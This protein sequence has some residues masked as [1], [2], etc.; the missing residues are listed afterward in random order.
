LSTFKTYC[1]QGSLHTENEVNFERSWAGLT[2]KEFTAEVIRFAHTIVSGEYD[3]KQA[4]LE[5]AKMKA[6]A[7][8][9]VVAKKPEKKK[10]TGKK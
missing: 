9:K 10:V 7:K 8:K 1:F 2:K 6:A 3:Q 4:V 5:E